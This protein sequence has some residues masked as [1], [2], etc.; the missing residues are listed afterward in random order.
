MPTTLD[1]PTD[2]N[3]FVRNGM[4]LSTPSMTP[5]ELEASNSSPRGLVPVL[6]L[7]TK[8]VQP[9]TNVCYTLK[10][11]R[12]LPYSEYKLFRAQ[13]LENENVVGDVVCKAAEGPGILLRSLRTEA[14]LYQ[15]RLVPL[16][17]DVV[18]KLIGY[19][20]GYMPDEETKLGVLVLEYVGETWPDGSS[21]TSRELRLVP[22]RILK[23]DI[24][25]FP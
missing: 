24:D 20:E 6:R 19:F 9:D 17:G 23:L 25:P 14:N 22:A 2:V 3:K 10:A 1:F 5:A 16:Q 18:P 8:P 15:G 7:P 11:P 21:W 12:P 4:Q 13:L